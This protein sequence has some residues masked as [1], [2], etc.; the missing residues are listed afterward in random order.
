MQRQ[1]LRLNL[2]GLVVLLIAIASIVEP[3]GVAAGIGYGVV[4]V[5]IIVAILRE[6]RRHR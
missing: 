4:L 6:R 5:A 3:P 1:R 2:L